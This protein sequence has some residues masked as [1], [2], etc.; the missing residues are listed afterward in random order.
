MQEKL[1]NLLGNRWAFITGSSRGVGQQIAIGLAQ[2]NCNIIVH[3]RLESSTE[4][5][6]QRLTSSGAQ[7]Y[8]VFGQIINLTPGIKDIPQLA[9]CSVE[10]VLPGALAPAL[11]ED[12]GPSG[13]LYAGQDYRQPDKQ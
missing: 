3:R 11:L 6:L 1:T 8:T 9:P 7:T 13:Q 2:P 12:N 4:A 10:T 5:T